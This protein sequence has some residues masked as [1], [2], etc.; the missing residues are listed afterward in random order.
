MRPKST[1]ASLVVGLPAVFLSPP[2]AAEDV[3]LMSRLGDL[4]ITEGALPDQPQDPWT[5]W[6][7][8]QAPASPYAVLDGDE[9]VEVYLVGPA[10]PTGQP[11]TV[12]TNLRLYLR[13]ATVSAPAAGHAVTG[14]LFLPDP[15]VE[16]MVELRFKLTANDDTASTKAEFHRA[17]FRHYETLLA[18]DIPGAAWFRH[19][20]QESRRIVRQSGEDPDVV[21]DTR[22]W[23]QSSPGIDRTLALISGGRAL[24]EN[25]QLDAVMPVSEQ[26]GADIDVDTIEGITVHEFDWTA[27]VEGLS[28]RRDTLAAYIPSDQHAVFFP[29][30]GAMVDLIDAADEHGAPVLQSMQP[31][32]EHAM[33]RERYEQQMCLPLDAFARTLGPQLINGVAATGSDPYLRTGSDVAI[34]FEAKNSVALNTAIAVRYAAAQTSRNAAIVRGRIE[35]VAYSG[36]QTADRSICSYMATLPNDVVVVTNSLTQLRRIVDTQRNQ[37]ASLDDLDEYVFFRDRYSKSDAQESA[38]II[39]SDATIRRWCGPRWRIATSRRTR[40]MA[41]MSDLQAEYAEQLADSSVTPGPLHTDQNLSWLGKMSLTNSGVHSATYGSL[42]F[43]TP[44]A[45]LD[46]DK[47][48]DREAEL[49]DRWRNGYERNWRN[50]FDPIAIRFSVSEER[51]GVDM[52]VMPLIARS[53]YRDLVE[54]TRDVSIAPDGADRHAGALLHWALAVNKDSRTLTGFGDTARMF[55]PDLGLEPLSWLGE[56]VAF[57]IED[58]PIWAA[59]DEVDDIEDFLEA[60]APQLPIALHVDVSNGF[61]L[62]AFITGARAFIEQTVPGMIEW[63]IREHNDRSYVAVSP[64]EKAKS[65]IPWDDIV[66]YYAASGKALIISLREDVLQAAL[67]RQDARAASADDAEDDNEPAN[68]PGDP[69]LGKSLCVQADQRVLPLLLAGYGFNYQSRMQNLAWG[70]LPILNEW[71]RMK[72]SADPVALHE[73]LW[74]MRLLCPGGGKYRWNEQWQTMESTVYGHPGAPK[75]G[76]VLPSMLDRI[77]RFNAGLTF[78]DDGLRA[79]V[80]LTERANDNGA[81]DE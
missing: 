39:L 27:L 48:T 55:V 76:P 64:S 80:Q 20:A 67:D 34:L 12:L 45:E 3:F 17:R 26:Q 28:P 7:R 44:I 1:V 8:I 68:A 43:Q 79:Q 42:D 5:V 46:V 10:N 77:T 58:D 23:R 73:H 54:I 78:T 15:A 25:L 62:A 61:K 30:F 13:T 11:A 2:V 49:Y 52:T 63:E 6:R 70:N 32:S 56:S 65:D 50:Y 4:E 24:S 57:Y 75:D 69:W 16:G 59:M 19:N 9:E 47:V 31:R 14:R 22:T 72:P 66:L 36:V 21:G 37:I 60:H 71:K 74:N 53:E 33:V 40:A 81:N 29:S 51:M 38:L 35:D 18:A 41:A